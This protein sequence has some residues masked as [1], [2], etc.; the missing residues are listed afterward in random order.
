MISLKVLR[1]FWVRH[2][3][4][5]RPLRHWYKTALAATWRNLREARADYPHA[6]GVVNRRGETLTVF[7][8]GGNKHRLV[9]RIRYDYQLINVRYVLTHEEYDAQR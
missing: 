1:A 4:A 8:V 7:N 6:D 3:A 2:A 9:V 5:E